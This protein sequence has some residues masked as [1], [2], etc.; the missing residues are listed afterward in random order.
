MKKFWPVLAM[1]LL[2][3]G[4]LVPSVAGAQEFI[5]TGCLPC[6]NEEYSKTDE[7]W[8]TMWAVKLPFEIDCDFHYACWDLD[9]CEPSRE[10]E[11]AELVALIAES[12]VAGLKEFAEKIEGK[13]KLVPERNLLLYESPCR[14]E[15]VGVY[16]LSEELFAQI[17]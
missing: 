16:Q 7:E 10:E 6:T 8:I 13:L 2:F 4:I 5:C 3:V 11:Q 9:E 14:K 17:E 1:G 15:V 12:N